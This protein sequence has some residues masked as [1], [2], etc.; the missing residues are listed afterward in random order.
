MRTNDRILDFDLDLAVDRPART[1]AA[2]LVRLQAW[3]G[4]LRVGVRNRLAANRLADLAERLLNDLG[5]SRGDVQDVLRGHGYA[6]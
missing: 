5:L 4:S 1:L 2:R 3:I 6:D